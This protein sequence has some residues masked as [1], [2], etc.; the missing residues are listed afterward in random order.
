[1]IRFV[2]AFISF[3]CLLLTG[4]LLYIFIPKK[5]KDDVKPIVC[6]KLNQRNENGKCVCDP[7]WCQDK[8]C[9]IPFDS[10]L[11]CS[12]SQC[13]ENGKYNTNTNMC[14]CKTFGD[15]FGDNYLAK[16]ILFN[17]SKELENLP[18]HTG[19]QCESVNI[20]SIITILKS[21]CPNLQGNVKDVGKQ[22]LDAIKN[23][24][25]ASL[26]KICG[27]LS[28]SES[29]SESEVALLSSSSVNYNY[30][31]FGSYSPEQKRVFLEKLK[32]NDKNYMIYEGIL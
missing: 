4:I 10:K 2:I 11:D 5:G 29:E 23:K 32:Y 17:F 19:K 28:G 14:D 30:P 12:I 1:M 9:S 13:G 16:T 15:L 21:T 7:G 27:I 25:W 31:E 22:I 26:I 6:T 24:K 3:F 20:S 18:Y 8:L